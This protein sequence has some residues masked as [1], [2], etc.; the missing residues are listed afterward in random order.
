MSTKTIIYFKHGIGNLIM[1]TP[2]IKALSTMDDSGKVDICMSSEWNDPR[3]SAF[4]EF[5]GLWDI[6]EDIINYPKQQFVKKYT[7]WFYTG[8]SEHSAAFD[9]FKTQNSMLASCPNW[10]NKTKHEIFW[11]MDVLDAYGYKGFPYPQE[12]PVKA[13]DFKKTTKKIYIG[14]C[15]GTYS[16][17]MKNSKQWH[18]FQE[19]TDTIKAKYRNAVIIKIGYREE[20]K[21][22]K[23]DIDYV[24]K[25]S[26]CESAFVI[27]QL[28][29][30]I[31]TDTANMHVADAL[32]VNTIGLF[33]G[34]FV[35]KNGP[36]NGTTRIVTA[37]LT[38][39]PCQRTE[40]FYHC[41]NYKCMTELKVGDVMNEVRK[42]LK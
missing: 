8:H 9:Y 25:L 32:N 42:A 6:V 20:L 18:Y 11:Y 36:I 37:G 29:L 12:V 24:N 3:R 34:T 41:E 30:F 2:V 17:R 5:F 1:L 15:N 38:C 39:Q 19:L 16:E 28:D 33:G 7:R 27:S 35:S 13:I 26:F 4:D 14:I 31:T 10:L 40:K 23:A 21:D 22:I